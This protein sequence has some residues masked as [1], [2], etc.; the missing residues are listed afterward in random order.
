MRKSDRKLLIDACITFY[1]KEL[2]IDKNNFCL[3]VKSTKGLAKDTNAAGMAYRIPDYLRIDNLSPKLYF[4][5]LDSSIAMEQL[6]QTI[7]HEMVH[8]KQFVKGQISYKGRSMYWLGNKV[9]KS[10]INYYDH[11]WEI[12]AWSKEKVLSAKIF[13]ILTKL[14]NKHY[15]KLKL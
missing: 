7:A 11:P 10:K 12:D 13:K 1:A 5:Q 6:I 8:I 4:M 15:A 9:V 14:Q 2:K 3:I